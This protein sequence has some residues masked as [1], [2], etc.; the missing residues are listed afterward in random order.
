MT[1]LAFALLLL[2]AVIGYLVNWR[3]ARAI[4]EGGQRLHS[5]MGFHGLF[6]L[7]MILVPVLTVLLLW[8]G[9]EGPVIN[10]MILASLP[11]EEL[12][13]LGSGAIQLISAE[14]RSIAGGRIFGTPEDWKL[15]AADRLIALRTWS[16]I[17]LVV[18]VVILS[19]G[20]LLFSRSRVTADF[21][22]RQ[23]SESIVKGLMI[24]CSVVA[25]FTTVGIIFALVFEAYRFFQIVPFTE[26]L[27]G[28][29]WEPQIPIREDQIAAEGAFGWLPVIIGT[30]VI[31]FVAM[32]IATPV[33]LLSAI[34][35]NEFAPKTVR[36][37]VKPVLEILSGVPTVVY[38]FFAILVVAPAL[39]GTGADLGIDIS[40]NTA[41]AAGGVMGIML[42]PFISSFA[43]DA[44]SA[45]P[46]SLRDGSLALGATRGETM[47]KVLFPAAIPGIVGG[48]LLAVSRAIGE[49]MIVVMAAGL[50]ARMTI[51]PLDSVTTVTVQI[52]TLLI[53]DTAF[54]NPKT[55]AAFALGLM[56][57]VITLGI[58]V[59]ALRIVRKY[60]E[61][62]D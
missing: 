55:L 33:G 2:A 57:F 50:M 43:D 4:R 38:G 53:G 7:L 61:I 13:G 3:A 11:A 41:L 30:L 23:A 48:V 8:L 60:R 20:I 14:I 9:F 32:F 46:R 18:V 16:D 49:T 5:L 62:Y 28:T 17:L 27:F 37:V 44:L 1:L 31:S 24:A 34:Y 52:V 22:A 21:R 36:A 51:N 29:N 15:D 40:S 58:N 6:S 56:L 42:I 39:R 10:R 12:E 45:V 25:I 19:L 35:L 59:L 47:R 54:D 26:F